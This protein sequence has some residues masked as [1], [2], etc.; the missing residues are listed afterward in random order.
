ML[1]PLAFMAVISLVLVSRP[2]VS[3]AA[4]RAVTG[5]P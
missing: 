2:I 5:S 1:M 4:M 3:K